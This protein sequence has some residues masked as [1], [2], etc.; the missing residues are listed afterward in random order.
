MRAIYIANTSH[1]PPGA[2]AEMVRPQ[3]LIFAPKP[4]PSTVLA[5]QNQILHREHFTGECKSFRSW[6]QEIVSHL[7][8]SIDLT[9]EDTGGNGVDSKLFDGSKFDIK[10]NVENGSCVDGNHVI[11][12]WNVGGECRSCFKGEAGSDGWKHFEDYLGGDSM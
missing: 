2:V 8:S 9:K 5:A 1:C 3:P 7:R 4:L 6:V 10:V 11:S 12:A